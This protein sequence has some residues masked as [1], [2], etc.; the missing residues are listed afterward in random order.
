[1]GL[2]VEDMGSQFLTACPFIND[3]YIG[4]GAAVGKEDT[5]TIVTV[6]F[7]FPPTS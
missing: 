6:K 5:F 1:M 7:G 2:I 4:R 3:I